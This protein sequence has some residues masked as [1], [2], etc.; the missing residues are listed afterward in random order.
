MV[1]HQVK[2]A[3]VVG[4]GVMGHGIAQVFAKAGVTVHLV[5]LNAQVL[6]SAF[7]R[8]EANLALLAEWG[9][10]SGE[11][12][13]GIMDRI[14]P[15]HDLVR[16][17]PTADFALE[18]VVEK[19]DV[20]REIFSQLDA[21]CPDETVI[22]SNTSSLDIFNIAEIGSPRRLVGCH[23]F[24]PAHIIPLVEVVPGPETDPEVVSLTASFMKQV[25]KRPLCLKQFIPGFVVNRIQMKMAEAVWEM[26]ENEWA[27]PEEIDLAVKMT[28]GIRLPIVGAVQTADFTGLD[29]V[30]DIMKAK[31]R[32]IPLLEEKIHQGDLGAKTG[33]GLFDYGGRSEAEILA[34]RDRRY[35]E[36]IRHLEE[37]GAFEPV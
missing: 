29:V 1:V 14:R 37:T 25:G 3:L 15:F 26:L 16:A 12:I 32:S 31:G 11:D 34:K 30:S 35:L 20:K 9:Q 27:T 22:G 19:P 2:T 10:I 7:K 6:E 13:P 28:L 24:A 36:M 21:L 33:R 23:W 18:A 8:M 17:A 4:A 5:D